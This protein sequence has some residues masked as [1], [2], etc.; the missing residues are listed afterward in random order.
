MRRSELEICVDILRAIAQSGPLK[1]THIMYKA[2]VNCNLLKASLEFML[3]QGLVEKEIAT[4]HGL[5]YTVTEKGKT[6]L[7]HFNE[8]VQVLPIIEETQTY[9][10]VRYRSF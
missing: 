10:A 6:V 2:N 5:V 9:V 1:L 7:Q 3:K 8:I 4:K